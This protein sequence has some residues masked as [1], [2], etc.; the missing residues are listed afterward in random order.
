MMEMDGESSKF[1]AQY[2][3]FFAVS[4]VVA[5]SGVAVRGIVAVLVPA[6]RKAEA[7]EVRGRSSVDV[8]TDPSLPLWY[9]LWRATLPAHP[10]LVGS[11]I[12]LSPIPS[13]A[14]VPDSTSAHMLWFGLAGALSGQIYDI[15]KRVA[16]LAPAIIRQR[17]NIKSE[18]P[19]PPDKDAG[20]E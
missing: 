15:S 2:W 1:V 7:V 12:G 17:F 4:V 6:E 14:W 19:P 5:M 9:R 10:I 3:S 18:P 13:A 16:E 20:Q 11:L 8:A